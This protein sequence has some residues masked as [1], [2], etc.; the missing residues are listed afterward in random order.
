MMIGVV[1]RDYSSTL[2]LQVCVVYLH[3]GKHEGN[4][5]DTLNIM[6]I[7]SGNRISDK[8]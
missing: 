2:L 4:T 1:T 7:F 6:V 3:L 8:F 5:G